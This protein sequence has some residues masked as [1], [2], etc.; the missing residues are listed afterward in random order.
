MG[1]LLLTWKTMEE[2]TQP[3]G[4]RAHGASPLR[5]EERSGRFPVGSQSDTTH[6]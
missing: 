1:N 3:A 4:N 6:G 2:P 5:R